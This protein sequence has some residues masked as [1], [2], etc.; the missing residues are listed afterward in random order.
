[1][2][3]ADLI[4][5]QHLQHQAGPRVARAGLAYYQQGRA[6]VLG[7]QSHAATIA[8][9]GSQPR[10]YAV[11]ITQQQQWLLAECSCPHAATGIT[12][13][14]IIAAAYQLRDHLIAHPP[15]PWREVFAATRQPRRRTGA[16]LLLFS[17][18]RRGTTW[19]LTPYTI[20]ERALPEDALEDAAALLK[21]LKSPQLISQAKVPRSPLQPHQAPGASAAAL[22]LANMV[23]AFSQMYYYGGT[24]QPPA[25]LASLLPLLPAE[26]VFTG[27]EARPFQ[28]PLHSSA[29]RGRVGLHGAAAADGLT[30]TPMIQ[31]GDLVFDL[32]DSA[33]KIVLPDYHWALHHE[34]LFQYDDPGELLASFRD[35]SQLTIPA[36]D[37]AEFIEQ[38]LLPL[39]ERTPLSGDLPGQRELVA[40]PQPRLYL[41]EAAGELLAELRFGYGAHELA[42]DPQHPE[43]SVIYQEIPAELL[44]IIRQPETEERFWLELMRHGLKR[45]PQPGVASLRAGTTA[46]TFLLSHVPKLAA[47]GFAIHGEEALLTARVNRHAPTITFRVASRIDWFDLEAVVRFGDAEINLAELR[48]AMLKRQRYVRLPDGSIGAIPAEWLERYRHLFALG[49]LQGDQ[50]RLLAHQVTVLDDL[51][52]DTDQVDAEF[53]RR[54]ERLRS[55][56]GIAPRDLPPGFTGVL[57]PYQKAGYDWLH[58]LHEYEFGGCLADDMGTGKTIQT[59][60]FLQSLRASGHAT[61]SSLIVLPRSLIFNWQREV[62]R[63]T[64]DLRVLVHASQGRSATVAEFAGYDLV[65][66]TYGTLLR[67]SELFRAYQFHYVVLDEAQVIKNPASQT[68]RAARALRSDHRLALTGTP[69]ENSTL[70]LWSQFA[71]L[72]PGMLGS[73]ENFRAEFVARIEKDGNQDAARLLRRMVGPFILRRTKD[74]VAPE[75]PERDERVLYCAM[76]PAQARLYQRYRDQYRALLLDLI[77]NDGINEVRLRVLEGLLRLRQICNHPRLVEPDFRGHSAKFELLL[78]TLET[79]HAEGHKVLVFSQFVKMLTLLR[80][81]LEQRGLRYAYLDGQTRARAAVVD[82][83]QADPQLPFFLI[84]LKAGGVGLNLT[85]ADYV[86]H[87]DPWWNPAVEQQATDRTHRIGQDKPVFIYKLIV[88]D[89]VEEKM[90]VL[91]ERKRALADQLVSSERG[92]VK[93]LTR[94]DVADLFS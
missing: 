70:E 38:Y 79:L 15:N 8:V 55:V 82:A 67:D 25:T 19:S 42:Y 43:Q 31:L 45:G 24:S 86:I 76:E 60:A 9:R 50:L 78:E 75:L 18:V 5:M 49:E 44:R 66:T 87:I 54:R 11:E 6:K 36:A 34:L 13:K 81:Q 94:E 73:L 77:D 33:L 85:A 92:I 80:E 93:S 64:P 22:A 28:R 84:S 68:A 7:I 83:F 12:C 41:G 71:F 63:W 74:Q 27:S 23:A 10:P 88:R 65:L 72:N 32:D 46:A 21:A 56:D 26:N 89:S 14:H 52:A 3:T 62:A 16:M 51:L 30:I 40:D 58:F 20:A 47:A 53:A 37:R 2:L 90:L 48:L 1:M 39:A 57:R 59:L 35:H 17:L 61:A 91:Q 4:D 29:E 69:V